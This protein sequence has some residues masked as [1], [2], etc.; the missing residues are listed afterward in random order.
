MELTPTEGATGK[1]FPIPSTGEGENGEHLAF[2]NYRRGTNRCKHLGKL[3]LKLKR[4]LGVS[5]SSLKYVHT[6]QKCAH[7]KAGAKCSQQHHYTS[8][9]LETTQSA[10]Q[11]TKE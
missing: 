7:Q 10:Q 1:T 4:H 3:W 8:P 11:W 2:S 6:Q 5:N 9:R